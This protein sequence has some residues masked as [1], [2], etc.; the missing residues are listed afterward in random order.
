MLKSIGKYMSDIILSFYL[1]LKT[2]DI[3][4]AF[5]AAQFH[6]TNQWVFNFLFPWFTC[7]F[8][9]IKTSDCPYLAATSKEIRVLALGMQH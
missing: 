6:D 5:Y 3:Q 8:L 2:E 4:F 7:N 1:K 9:W